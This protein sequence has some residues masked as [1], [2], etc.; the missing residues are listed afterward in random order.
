MSLVIAICVGSTIIVIGVE[1][2]LKTNGFV[3]EG[4]PIGQGSVRCLKGCISCTCGYLQLKL[5]GQPY[6]GIATIFGHPWSIHSI[7]IMWSVGLAYLVLISIAALLS[8]SCIR[9]PSS[10]WFPAR[11]ACSS[12]PTHGSDRGGS[13]LGMINQLIT[14]WSCDNLST[15]SG[16][17]TKWNYVVTYMHTRC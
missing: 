12:T 2:A 8:R 17:E 1:Q 3:V 16:V 6:S 4:T 14:L 7:Q 9:Y 15:T 10:Q 13:E 5:W 11:M